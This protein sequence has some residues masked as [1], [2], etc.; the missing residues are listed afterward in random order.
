MSPVSWFTKKIEWIQQLKMI[1]ACYNRV[2]IA[3][4]TFQGI[5]TSLNDIIS[6]LKNLLLGGAYAHTPREKFGWLNHIMFVLRDSHKIKVGS[7]L[8]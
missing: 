1:N 4:N 6:F 3:L 2:E 5:F 8:S 7:K